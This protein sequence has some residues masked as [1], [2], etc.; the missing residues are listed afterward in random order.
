LSDA[1]DIQLHAGGISLHDDHIVH[2]SEGNSSAGWRIGLAIRYSPAHV[3]C[4]LE[5]WPRF[6]TMP[7]RGSNRLNRNPV[8]QPPTSR[9]VQFIQTPPMSTP[10]ARDRLLVNRGL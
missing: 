2:G 6:L 8:A 3:V 5:H 4:D 9:L 7:V 1:V 10:E